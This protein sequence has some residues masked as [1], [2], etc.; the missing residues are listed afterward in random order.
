[1]STTPFYFI[2]APP[3]DEDSQEQEQEKNQ[4]K[5]KMDEKTAFG[6]YA[7]GTEKGGQYTYRVRKS[8]AYGGYAIV[9]EVFRLLA[10]IGGRREADELSLVVVVL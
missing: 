5:R 8:G 6:T 9:K 10:W 4:K 3:E 7:G 2:K 1:V